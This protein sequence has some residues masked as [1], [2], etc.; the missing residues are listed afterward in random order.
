MT[1]RDKAVREL[2]EEIADTVFR[3]A[4][5]PENHFLDESEEDFKRDYADHY[6]S[7]LT[8]FLA[9]READ[10]DDRDRKLAALEV[11]LKMI[12]GALPPR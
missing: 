2:A 11:G 9:E 12:V 4:N 6:E 8:A 1:D 5:E 10:A 7:T 3:H